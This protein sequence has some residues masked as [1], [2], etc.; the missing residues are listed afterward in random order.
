MLDMKN[1]YN[2][3]PSVLVPGEGELAEKCRENGIEVIVSK[4]YLWTYERRLKVR[5]KGFVKVL[6]NKIYYERKILN[7]LKNKHFDIVHTN[8][9]VIETGSIIAQKLNVPHVWHIREYGIDDYNLYYLPPKSYVKKQYSKAAQIITISNSVY[10]TYVYGYGIIPEESTR[11]IYDGLKVPEDYTKTYAQDGR[12]NFCIVGLLFSGKNQ[13]TAIKACAK[14]KAFTDKFML[15]I[16]GNDKG[17]YPDMLKDYVHSHGL[18]DFVKF[19]GFRYD[20]NEIL[21]TMDVGLMLSRR[22]A[23]G[24]VTVEYMLNYM[25]VIGVNSGATPEIVDDGVTGYVCPL[26]DEEYIAAVMRKFIDNPELLS[27]MGNKGR[28]RAVKNFSLER[29]TDEIYSLYQEILS[30]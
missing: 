19:W 3:E 22:E 27:E 11:I 17:E 2:V 28:E 5:I 9:S 18:D 6:L 26:N 7:L 25:P 4:S 8:S 15:H 20:V 30:R 16:I 1:R 12:V 13:L 23:F 21:K 29:N 10:S 14:L 24:R